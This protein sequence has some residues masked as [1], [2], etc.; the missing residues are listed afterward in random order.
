M[1]KNEKDTDHC[2]AARVS[3]L[4]GSFS[5]QCRGNTDTL[6]MRLAQGDRLDLSSVSKPRAMPYRE[7][8]VDAGRE[9]SKFEI[10]PMGKANCEPWLRW[11]AKTGRK[12]SVHGPFV[13]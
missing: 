4:L 1:L 5:I 9:T 10:T 11:G 2:E 8:Q 7:S 3:I 13:L 12:G 6:R